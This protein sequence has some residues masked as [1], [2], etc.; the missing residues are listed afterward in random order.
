MARRP[1]G[2]IFVLDGKGPHLLKI[3]PGGSPVALNVDSK[4][5]RNGVAVDIGSDNEVVVV[6]EDH[7]VRFT[8][9]DSFDEVFE[10]TAERVR[11][12]QSAA[13]DKH[14]GLFVVLD[15]KEILDTNLAAKYRA[16]VGETEWDKMFTPRLIDVDDFGNVLIFGQSTALVGRS[17]S[18]LYRFTR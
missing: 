13:T 2:T 16:T 12:I 17:G 18:A 8:T 1:E 3:Q 6:R 14:G 7:I 5:L 4:L 10:D 11:D 15:N 9:T